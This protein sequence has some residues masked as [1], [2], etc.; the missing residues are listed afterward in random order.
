MRPTSK[1]APLLLVVAAALVM[2]AGLLTTS[3]LARANALPTKTNGVLTVAIEL[4][5][6]G[7]AEGTTRNPRGFSI[8]VAKAVAK[9]MRLRI[10]FVNYPFPR[11]FLPGPKPYDIAFEF[12]TILPGRSRF[13]DFSTPQISTTQAVL[14]ARD[15]TGPVTLARLR[16]L[17]MCA[18]EFTTGFAYVQDVLR[19]EGLVL[20]YATAVAALRALS[21]SICD[22]F[23]FDLPALIAAKRAASARYGALA[24]RVGKTE[25]YGGVL[26]KGSPLRP[27]VNKAITSLRRDGTMRRI[28]ARHFGPALTS[29]PFIR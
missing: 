15:I 14:V 2:S 28:G 24:G 9:R 13:V 11:L 10:R 21:R 5:N 12:V 1:R 8:D 6:P 20:E 22:A 27:A 25:H 26:P 19:P 3:A 16:K 29:T 18:K 23:V 4:G 17:Q 7:F